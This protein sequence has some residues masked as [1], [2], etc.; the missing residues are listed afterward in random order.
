[1]K[2]TAHLHLVPRPK[3][4]WS[5]ISIP[6]ETPLWHGIQLKK[7]RHNFI[8]I[9]TFYIKRLPFVLCRHNFT[10]TFALV[11]CRNQKNF[12]IKIFC[13]LIQRVSIPGGDWEFFSSTP[14]SDRLWGP[15]SLLFIGYQGL[16]PW[17]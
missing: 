2:L 10:L 3:N 12:P 5:H 4:V 16:F 7:H 15:P 9:F 17:W 8:F 14:C 13:I 6:P 1:V 11:Y